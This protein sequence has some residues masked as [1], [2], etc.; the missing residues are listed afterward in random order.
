M[1]P[2]IG[3]STARTTLVRNFLEDRILSSRSGSRERLPSS[4]QLADELGVSR[5]T[6]VAAYQE[7]VSEGFAEAI[8]RSGLYINREIARLLA[9][10][11]IPENQS[12]A[13]EVGSMRATAGPESRPRHTRYEQD[14]FP[15]LRKPSHWAD[16]PYPFIYGQIDEATFPV[17]AWLRYLAMALDKPHRR[18][19]LADRA[20]EDDPLLVEMICR[21]VLP[22]RGINVHPSMV[23]TTMGTQEGLHLIGETLLEQGSSV[24]VEDP[25]YPDARHIFYRAGLQL[26]PVPVDE[27]GMVIEDIPGGADM[28]YVT[29]S[30]QF[31]TNV[32]LSIARRQ[33][34]VDL[35]RSRDLLI[36]E[37]DYDSEFRFQGRPTPALKSLER[38]GPVLYL[39]SFSKLLAPGLRLGFLVA[40]PELV[41]EVRRHQRYVLRHPPGHLQRALALMIA[42]DAY[43]RHLR[44]HRT[45]L[46]RKWQAMS[47]G[48]RT[49]LPV[50]PVT[51]TGGTSFWL[52][53]PETLDADRLAAEALD[54]GVV[55]EPGRAFFLAP[56]APA[57]HFRLGFA[58][59][60]LEAIGPGLATL[61][62]LIEVSCHR[63]GLASPL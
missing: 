59:I 11:R 38:A 5:N 54:A 62:H 18:F 61:A 24:A 25:G 33:R 21:R 30:H 4:R 32:T 8:P 58:A 2:D 51:M 14:C 3:R 12:D 26:Q 49:L 37:D 28:T 53:G 44:R 40:P 34:L 50:S 43:G 55:I 7:L 41:S 35:A 36:I 45:I 47:D 16:V 31:P 29:P 10:G 20:E 15:D 13:R 46:R 39:G 63:R 9:E 48:I 27:A 1:V 6:V 56:D 60:S 22:S 42:D 23:M 52:T 17:A 57:N 19:S